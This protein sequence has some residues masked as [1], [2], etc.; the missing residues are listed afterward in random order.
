M[1][2][3]AAGA[4]GGYDRPIRA[5]RVPSIKDLPEPWLSATRAACRKLRTA[6]FRGWIVGGAVRDLALGRKPKDAD[7]TSAAPPEVIEEL[8]E[9]THA[10]GKAFGTV[11]VLLGDQE[12]EVTT[13]RSEGSYAD[14]RR[15]D[16]VAWG[17]TPEEDAR[18]R[19]FTSNALFLDPLED[20]LLDPTG[21]LEDIRAG[22]LRCV[23]DPRERFAEDGLRILRLARFAAR[24]GWQVEATTLAGARSSLEALRGL[25][26]ERV[27][28]ELE[29]IGE[30]ERPS[31]AVALLAACG[32]L[33][34]LF[35]GL[36]LEAHGI[37]ASLARA[38]GAQHPCTGTALF[39]SLLFGSRLEGAPDEARAGLERLRPS[40]A[41]TREVL[42]TWEEA[43]RLLEFLKDAGPSSRG[44]RLRLVRAGAFERA[45]RF[46]RARD[47]DPGGLGE[48]EELRRQTTHE[49]LFPRPWLDGNDL[50]AL[51]VPPGP[52]YGELLAEAEERRLEG[53]HPDRESALGWLRERV[54]GEGP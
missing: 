22:R 8:F 13:F 39:L 11:R 25:S 49:E 38:C 17:A 27:L 47:L 51:G 26:V 42:E 35:P 23:G 36:G 3:L 30:G 53:E 6:G 40:R 10:V 52:L 31:E 20:E 29:G 32:A 15:P 1:S 9:R 7:L 50:A 41:L 46:L 21:G 34:R 48:L 18:R 43:R 16:R 5:M 44:A 28:Q 12:L 37:E 33:E 54:G 19:D 2:R 24:Y 4:S 45:V 14:G